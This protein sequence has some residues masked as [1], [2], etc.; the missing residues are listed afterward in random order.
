MELRIKHKDTLIGAW[1]NGDSGNVIISPGLP[2]YIDKHHS[3][4]KY[5]SRAGYN[6]FT[7]RYIGSWESDGKFSIKNCVETLAQTLE[8]IRLGEGIESYN[9][10]KTSWSNDIPTYLIGFSFGALPVLLLEADVKKILVCPFVSAAYH[11]GNN[12][13]E[14]IEHT[15]EFLFRGYPNVY[16]LDVSEIM[17]ELKRVKYPKECKNLT[18]VFGVEDSI[19]PPAEIDFLIE[20]Y[21]PKIVSLPIGHSL[22]DVDESSIISL[23]K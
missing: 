12:S 4:I 18:I 9:L 7:P 3:V 15:F 11:T 10:A 21:T 13:G 22:N 16:R 1:L 14:D 19:I 6:I 8:L 5:L 23:L 20:K 17:M 2:Q